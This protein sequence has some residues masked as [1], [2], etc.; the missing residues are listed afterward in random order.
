MAS[1][2]WDNISQES[3]ILSRQQLAYLYYLETSHTVLQN[4]RITAFVN[5]QLTPL[6]CQKVKK[7]QEQNRKI[8]HWKSI[9]DISIWYLIGWVRFKAPGPFGPQKVTANLKPCKNIQSKNKKQN[10]ILYIRDYNGWM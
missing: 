3:M 7:Q 2:S 4:Y 5:L 1:D 8:N 6:K 10:Q 9:I